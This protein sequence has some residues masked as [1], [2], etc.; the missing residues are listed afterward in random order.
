[1]VPRAAALPSSETPSGLK[2]SGKIVMMSMRMPRHLR[3]RL[4]QP[5]L[6]PAQPVC[7]PARATSARAQVR[8]SGRAQVEQ[9]RRRVNDQAAGLYIDLR[10]DGGHERDEQPVTARFR[11]LDHEEVLPMMA[12]IRDDP[13]RLAGRGDHRQPHQLM[14]VELV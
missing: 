4:V 14:I 2:Y 13:D 8:P 11:G 5:M 10:H 1:M 3:P 6:S 7:A 9:A 12:D